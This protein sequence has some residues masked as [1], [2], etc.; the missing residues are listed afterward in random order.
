MSKPRILREFYDDLVAEVKRSAEPTFIRDLKGDGRELKPTFDA[1][2][3]RY[4]RETW[5]W[6]DPSDP[7]LRVRASFLRFLA[8]GGDENATVSEGGL[9]LSGA[10]IGEDLDLTGASV[11][12]PLRFS[13]CCFTRSIILDDASAKTLDLDNC[14]VR[15]ISGRG[16]RIQGAVLIGRGF[17]CY[18]GV[19]FPGAVI[20]GQLRASSGAFLTANGAALDASAARIAGD[21][22][23]ADG[24]LGQGGV[25]FAGAKIGGDLDGTGGAFHNRSE[26]GSSMALRCD[27]AEIAGNVLLRKP[28]RAHGAVSFA[29]A[30]IG[31]SVDCS[32]GAF[33]NRAASGAS[34]ALSL[35][36]AT[37]QE[38]VLLR[39]GFTAEGKIRLS[40]AHIKGNLQL[41]NGHFDNAGLAKQEASPRRARRAAAAINLRGAKIDGVLWLAP[42]VRGPH[43][44]AT[45]IGSLN[46]SGAYAHEI[47]DHPGSWPRKKA[48][49]DGAKSLPAFIYL[50][51]F[52]YDRL[53]GHG[54]YDPATR[55]RWLERQPPE[56]LGVD[57]RPQP[58]EQLI[59]VYREMGH[60]S[61]ARAIAKFKERRR[62]RSLFSKLWHGWRDRPKLSNR[63]G[64]NARA[65]APLDW[66]LW[67]VTLSWRTISRAFAT[68]P[69]ALAWAFVGFGTAYWYG[70]GRVLLFLLTL[71]I[72]GGAFYDEVA[73]QGGFAP[74][75]PAIYLNEKLVAKCGKHW[76]DCK[77]APPELPG[78]SPYIYSL[79]I[80]L[81][82]LDL[83][84]KHDWQPIDRTD[85]PV[86]LLQPKFTWLPNNDLKHSEIPDFDIKAQPIGEGAA[87]AIVRAQ[88]LLGWGAL[89]LLIGMLSGLIKKD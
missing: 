8:L 44:Q 48:R 42:P 46:L 40:G 38:N 37:V 10:Y 32:G 68:I 50:D 63:F 35:A 27:H 18:E 20:E 31:G 82:V 53:M 75:N 81:P 36:F 52:V 29:G 84:Q 11:R 80:M 76:T 13:R 54:D 34:D 55:K 67:P 9:D 64:A 74:S 70:W 30:K 43:G 61:H 86:E 14:G 49:A 51:G 26:D 65:A 22:E 19:S 21:V 1:V 33:S 89:G 25:S 6:I 58:F 41:S 78:F 85:R 16:A 73:S 12:Q 88:T 62:Y 39:D 79:D 60:D 77:G 5:R 56:H 4:E 17:R 24:F 28:F 15:S 2:F 23:L 7:T 57:F 59:K 72:A 3:A 71:W 66:L 69:L 47:V 87:D 83:G 45:I